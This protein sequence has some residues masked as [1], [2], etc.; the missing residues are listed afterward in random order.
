MDT[1]HDQ[2][3]A[4]EIKTTGERVM[5]SIFAAMGLLGLGC[6]IGLMGVGMHYLPGAW[7]VW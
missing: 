4:N 3:A 5:L 2:I 1:K 7:G 6:A